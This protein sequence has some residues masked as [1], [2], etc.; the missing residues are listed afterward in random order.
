MHELFCLKYLWIYIVSVFEQDK[1]QEKK[2]PVP[3]GL[4]CPCDLS[5][6]L[7]STHESL[8]KFDSSLTQ[9]SRVIV[10]SA[11]KIKD[12]SRVELSHADRLF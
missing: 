10:E 5:V 3:C 12:M 7:C 2:L 9:M 4:L 6:W 1:S 8:V 11:V